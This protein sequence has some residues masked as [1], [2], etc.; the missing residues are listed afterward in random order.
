GPAIAGADD[1]LV[2]HRIVLDR[3]PH[4]AAATDVPAAVRVPGLER[5]F[6]RLAFLRALLRVVR[7]GPE[8]PLPVAAAHV[9]G[10]HVATHVVLGAGVAD[11]HQV[12]GDLGRAGDRVGAPAID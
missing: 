12:A 7:D 2:E 4:R 1:H 6:E 5:L 8:A 11:D 10:G 9:V 3:V